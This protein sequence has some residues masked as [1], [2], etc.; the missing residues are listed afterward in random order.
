MLPAR[1]KNALAA[2]ITATAVAVAIAAILV[3]TVVEAAA[4]GGIR[5]LP[6][7]TA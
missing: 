6:A 1:G 2:D 5:N 4:T 3:E 7:E